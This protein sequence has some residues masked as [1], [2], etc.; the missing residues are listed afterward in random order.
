MILFVK[1]CSACILCV[2]FLHLTG[3][4][5]RLKRASD[6][7]WQAQKYNTES[8]LQRWAL[9]VFFN[10]FKLI[11]YFSTSPIKKPTPSQINLIKNAKN[12]FLLLK[13]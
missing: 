12:H 4:F 11:T 5:F 7:Y 3:L 2:I 9:S 8:Q 10:F 13:K 1:K 6:T